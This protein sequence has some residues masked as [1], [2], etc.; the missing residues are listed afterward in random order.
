M[1]ATALVFVSMAAISLVGCKKD[2]AAVARPD[3]AHRLTTAQIKA[4]MA[5][6]KGRWRLVNGTAGTSDY[7]T[8]GTIHIDWGKGSAD[9]RWRAKDDM[10]C[11]T[12]P[13]I[14]NGREACYIVYKTGPKT[15][16]G[17]S[18]GRQHNVV[19]LVE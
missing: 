16:V 3:P 17:Y 6:H 19:T 18:G 8:D 7:R 10:F 15:I 5:G 1:R 14:R 9:G 13:T 12:Y 11:V 4:T 2:M